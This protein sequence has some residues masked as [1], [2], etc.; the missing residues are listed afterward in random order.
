MHKRKALPEER[1][2]LVDRLFPSPHNSP[3]PSS[4]ELE[5]PTPLTCIFTL[6]L[7][8]HRDNMLLY[9]AVRSLTVFSCCCKPRELVEMG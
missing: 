2:H 3:R 1:P 5:R 6:A 7:C 9:I 8:Q 4:V